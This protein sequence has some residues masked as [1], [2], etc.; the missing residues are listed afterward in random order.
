MTVWRATF[1]FFKTDEATIGQNVLHFNNPDNLMDVSQMGQELDNFF[2]AFLKPMLAPSVRLEVIYFR[3]MQSTPG[4]GTVPWVTQLTTGTGS[5]NA[6]HQCMG[7]VF[8]FFD[9][10]AGP[11][12]RG[13]MYPYCVNSGDLNRQGPQPSL[14]T[15]FNTWR[16]NM[17]GRYIT[18]TGV[19]PMKLMLH[20]RHPEGPDFTFV[21]DLRLAPRLGVQRRRNF[22]VGL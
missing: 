3:D 9:G 19:S 4:A 10:Q 20:H 7:P 17:F 12:H 21:K 1:Q 11:R 16:T 14:V 15:K 2:W 13:R 22:G 8:Q 5:F 18:G 6:M